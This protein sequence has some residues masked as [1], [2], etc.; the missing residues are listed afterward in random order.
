MKGLQNAETWKD[1]KIFQ[2][3]STRLPQRHHCAVQIKHA[4]A[5]SIAS[6]VSVELAC[7]GCAPSELCVSRAAS[8]CL[9]QGLR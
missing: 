7:A 8:R 2:A 4:I 6:S 9:R 3:L 5:D 1:S